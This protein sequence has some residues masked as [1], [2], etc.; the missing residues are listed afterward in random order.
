MISGIYNSGKYVQVQNGTPA[1]PSLYNN[2][3]GG[4][5]NGPQVF[6]GQIRY[7]TSNQ[8]IEVF[9]GSMWQQ[10]NT[11]VANVGLTV[12]AEQILDWA[13][14]KMLEELNLM[15]RMEQHP[16]LKDAWEKFKIMDALT[17]EESQDHG[18]V[19]SSP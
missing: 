9:D 15:I 16:G 17:L 3:H 12:E 8:C 13:K 18:E 11:S 2:N 4:Q 6:T 10:W 7:N 14:K 19:Q 5:S 1:R